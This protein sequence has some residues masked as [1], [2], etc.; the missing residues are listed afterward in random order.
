M[1]YT[2][3][4]KDFKKARANLKK[5]TAALLKRK[6][7]S[8][9]FVLNE[10]NISADKLEGFIASQGLFEQKYIVVLDKCL[11]DKENKEIVLSNLK[12]ISGSDNI[13]I[14]IEEGVDKK[15]LTKLEKKSEKVYSYD[16]KEVSTKQDFK[17]FTL[18]DSL[19]ERNKKKAWVEYQKAVINGSA[20]EEV[21]SMLLWQVR[22]MVLAKTS[23]TA[24]ESGLSPFVYG[25]SKKFASNYSEQE[26]RHLYKDLVVSYHEARRGGMDLNLSI[27]NILLA[28]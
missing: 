1:L 27:E 18:T 20:A 25:K 22:S 26:I 8:N 11:E 2:I 12:E 21:H 23:A 14:C 28:I 6:P 10:E 5:L 7:D 19:G 3:Y 9:L 15:T 17:L 4:G 16:V 24:N 13:F